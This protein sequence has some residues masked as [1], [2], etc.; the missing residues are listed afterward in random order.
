M[1]GTHETATE[2]ARSVDAWAAL[3]RGAFDLAANPIPEA[4]VAEAFGPDLHDTLRAQAERARANGSAIVGAIVT[5]AGIDW[6][7]G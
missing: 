1:I 4:A 3:V 5:R 6:L 2:H 7:E